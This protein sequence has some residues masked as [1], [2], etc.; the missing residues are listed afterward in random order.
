MF[1]AMRRDAGALKDNAEELEHLSNE[2]IQGWGG[3]GACYQGDALVML[4]QVQEGM[5]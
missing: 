1:N 5:A 3:T 2:T 4:G